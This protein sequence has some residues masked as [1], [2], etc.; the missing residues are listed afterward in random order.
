M[1][2]KRLVNFPRKILKD[3]IPNSKPNSTR[4]RYKFR[5]RDDFMKWTVITFVPTPV[6]FPRLLI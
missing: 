3:I 1:C 4:H 6:L 5:K 2:G